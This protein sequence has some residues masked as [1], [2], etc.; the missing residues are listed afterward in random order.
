MMQKPL[1][2]PPPDHSGGDKTPWVVHAST[3]KTNKSWEAL[4]ERAPENSRRCYE[5]LHNHPTQP[6]PRRVFPL[7]GKAHRGAWEYEAT[8]GDRVFYV[9]D[10]K[11]CTVIVYYAGKHPPK[12]PPPNI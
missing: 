12:A 11:S 9:P 8:G 6:I 1:L 4:M 3:S 5:H 2:S 7:R 10:A